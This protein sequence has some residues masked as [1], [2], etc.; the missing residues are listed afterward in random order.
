M[1]SVYLA[2]FDVFYPDA[3]AR[4][5]YL[6]ALCATHGLEGLYPLDA[7]LPE[8]LS[9]PAGWICQ[10]NLD[11][12]RRADAVLAN[13]GHFRGNEP[14]SG[15]VFE[16]GFACALGKPVWAYFPDQQ[17]MIEQLPRDE[18]GL[19][20]D[21]FVVENFGLPRNLMLACSWVGASR[22]APQ[23]VAEL[24]AWLHANPQ[25]R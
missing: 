12:L 4:G 16:V 23:A 22:T 21:G 2:G 11:S 15:T 25:T 13:L 19:C 20:P 9:D 24:A 8:G 10:A 18:Q 7:A 5:D 6:K 3:L 17:P 14:D 1:P